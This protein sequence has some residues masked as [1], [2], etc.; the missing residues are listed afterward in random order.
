VV[1]FYNTQRISRIVLFNSLCLLQDRDTMETE[2]PS[3]A[4]DDEG[5]E[6]AAPTLRYVAATS[7]NAWLC[8]GGGDKHAMRFG[9]GDGDDDDDAAV[10][11]TKTRPGVVWD[12]FTTHDEVEEEEDEDE[13][14]DDGELIVKAP[15]VVV[16][17]PA[18]VVSVPNTLVGALSEKL[19]F[20]G[21]PATGA[22]LAVHVAF[23]AAL[24]NKWVQARF[25]RSLLAIITCSL[26][27]IT[28]RS[29]L[30]ITSRSLLSITS[31]SL[32]SITSSSLLSIT[33]RSLLSITSR[34]LLSII[35]C[36]P[37]ATKYSL[38]LHS[39]P[40][41]PYLTLPYLTLPDLT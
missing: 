6:G 3:D 4:L 14:D 9:G 13:Y 22:F 38:V 39:F 33:S 32:L 23:E 26:L 5:E 12:L 7:D 31:R 41:L 29:L 21:A 28:S 27:S 20:H 35:T 16:E 40:F 2:A 15:K 10:I 19:R 30:S 18:N 17:V 24:N 11:T 1:P 37:F 25:S 8:D 36:L 34:A